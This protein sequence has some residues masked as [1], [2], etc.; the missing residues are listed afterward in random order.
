MNDMTQSPVRFGAGDALLGMLTLPA[1]RPPLPVACLMLNM[2]ANHR[3]GPRRINVKLAQAL[4]LRGMASLRLDLGGIG[5]SDP[6]AGSSALP[7]AVRAVHDLQAAMDL[8]EARLGIGQFVIVGMCSGVEHA[9][10]TA[11]LDTRV[12][13]LSLFD[14]FA[15]PQWRARWERTLR[16]MVAAPLHP[17][18]AGKVRRWAQRGLAHWLT[19]GAQV[20]PLPGFFSE[21]RSPAQSQAW[22][23]LTTQRLAER[24]VALH[25]I[26][27][28]SLQVNDRGRD[29]LGHFQHEP[30]AQ[31][32]Q[33]DFVRDMDH[34]LC[35]E[36]G[37]QLFL[38][39]VGDWTIARAG[40]V[41][42]APRASLQDSTAA[43]SPSHAVPRGAAVASHLASH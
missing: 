26:Y 3:V 32:A 21:E 40:G 42:V 6:P 10:T 35:T 14:G 41:A 16:R 12:V 33:Y 29:L 11:V 43:A 36:K 37:Q 15:F 2:G 31:A 25:F 28:G 19:G 24:Q 38:R 30:F 5:D 20:Q 17:A 7:L 22:F 1:H 27:S 39:A 8:V 4:A 23:G 13:G 9:M 34:T 18:F